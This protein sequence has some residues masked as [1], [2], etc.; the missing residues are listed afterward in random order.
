[1]RALKLRKRPSVQDLGIT[2]AG[3]N[4]QRDP[5][6]KQIDDY[7]RAIVE[8]RMEFLNAGGYSAGALEQERATVEALAQRIGDALRA[9]YRGRSPQP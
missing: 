5:G 8:A 2:P 9:D 1:M 6:L 4:V 7:Q 3:V